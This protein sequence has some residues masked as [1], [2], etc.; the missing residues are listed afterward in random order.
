MIDARP[1]VIVGDTPLRVEDVH[2]VANGVSVELS[3][4][5]LDRI[6]RSRDVIEEKLAAEEP[7]YGLNRGLGHD[8]DRR[9]SVGELTQF[10]LRMLRSHEG[11]LGALLPVGIES[12]GSPQYCHPNVPNAMPEISAGQYK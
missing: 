11:G 9:I 12:D 5:A 8:K 4:R 3:P 6:R 7:T 2:A 1:Q 10:S